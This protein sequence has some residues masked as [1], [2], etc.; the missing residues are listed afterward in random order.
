MRLRRSKVELE[1]VEYSEFNRLNSVILGRVRDLGSHYLVFNQ[2]G[3]C[4]LIIP[5]TGTVARQF[6]DYKRAKSPEHVQDP[7]HPNVTHLNGGNG[8]GK[9]DRSTRRYNHPPGGERVKEDP[10]KDGGRQE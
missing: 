10:P 2:D 8:N 6:D 1:I 5:V 3:P 4:G 7:V 9:K